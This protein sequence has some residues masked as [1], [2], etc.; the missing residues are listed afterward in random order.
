MTAK[1]FVPYEMKTSLIKIISYENKN[2]EGFLINPFFKEETYFQNVTQLLFLM[3]D[4]Y[5]QLFF[6][7][8][9]ME[10]RSFTGAKASPSVPDKHPSSEAPILASFKI[11]VLFRQNASWQGNVIWVE[12]GVE[13]Q[14]RSV[15]ELINLLDT[16]LSEA[17]LPCNSAE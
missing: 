13:A 1:K 11:S 16:V 14:F 15:L 3:D 17:T 10:I 12:K 7:Q 6:P 2:F 5:N 9:S 8:K 4:A